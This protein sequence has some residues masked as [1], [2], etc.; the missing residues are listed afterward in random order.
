MAPHSSILAWKI[1]LTEKPGGLQSHG[2]H[3][4]TGHNLVTKQQ[5]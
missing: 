5:Q 4:R 3:K 1:S 2:G